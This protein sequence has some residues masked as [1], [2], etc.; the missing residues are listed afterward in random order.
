VRTMGWTTFALACLLLVGCGGGGGGGGAGGA[1]AQAQPMLSRLDELTEALKGVQTAEQAKALAP[2]L[3]AK[4]KQFA[5]E[6]RRFL[7][8]RPQTNVQQWGADMKALAER[9]QAYSKECM[10]LA[11]QDPQMAQALAKAQKTV[12]DAQQEAPA[13]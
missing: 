11:T 13:N 1:S 2:Q 8:S 5:D 4:S 7:T 3:E 10:R 12:T 9:M 6:Y